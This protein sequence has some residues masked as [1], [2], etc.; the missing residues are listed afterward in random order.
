MNDQRW[1]DARRRRA[2]M[3]EVADLAGVAISSV[4][5]VLSGHPDVSGDMRERVLDAVRQLEYEPDFLAQSLR[6]GATLSVGW[7]IGDISNPLMASMTSGAESVLRASGYSM[8]LMNSENDPK[9]D[10][11]H[12]RFF[13]TRRVDG[14]I[15]SLASE[16]EPATL[17]VLGQVDVPIVLVDREVPADIAASGVRNDHRPGI[18]AAVEHL[19]DLGHR[20]IALI[21]G[22]LDLWP[23]RERIAGMHDAV[24]GRGIPDETITLTG[25]LSA[26]HGEAATEEILRMSPRPTAIIAGG[27]QVLA[28]CVR[29]LARHDVRIPEDMSFVTCDE[30][31]LSE[32]HSPP[33]ASVGRDTVALGRIAAELLLKR[34]TGSNEPETVVLPTAFTPRASCAPPPAGS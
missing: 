25:S 27:N 34:I 9:L 21:T 1:A 23:V 30:V 8:L 10:A 13:Q 19:V 12:I 16:L 28:G 14:M 31:A 3:R 17:E 29:A 2:S 22:A 20:R 18:R 11:A 24:A 4:S 7:V 32:L 15:L 6:R 5:R 26:E 33:I